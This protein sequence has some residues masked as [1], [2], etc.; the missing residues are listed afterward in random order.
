[1]NERITM[2]GL[3]STALLLF[4]SIVVTDASARTWTDVTGKYK[5]EADFVEAS[6]DAVK[7]RRTSGIVISVPLAKL[8]AADPVCSQS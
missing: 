4:V 2:R 3:L 1:M 8:S 6:A 7:L 5:I